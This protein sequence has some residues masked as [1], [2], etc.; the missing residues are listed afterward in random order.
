MTEEMAKLTENRVGKIRN[1]FK[2]RRCGTTELREKYSPTQKKN[3][4]NRNKSN[5]AKQGII[6][7]TEKGKYSPRE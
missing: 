1:P 4:T 3:E 7:Q 5:S 2:E 6:T